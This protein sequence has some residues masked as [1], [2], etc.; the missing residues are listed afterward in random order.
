MAGRERRGG[1]STSII[2]YPFC[3]GGRVPSGLEDGMYVGSPYGNTRRGRRDGR[4]APGTH[5]NA[6]SL[7]RDLWRSCIIRMTG[8]LETSCS[9]EG[10]SRG[11]LS[12]ARRTYL[13][14]AMRCFFSSVSIADSIDVGDCSRWI[15]YRKKSISFFR[16][17]FP[18]RLQ[19][20]WLYLGGDEIYWAFLI[21]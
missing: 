9:S 16:S 19:H 20:M 14:Y 6:S 17:F 7:R 8:Q 3:V 2:T 11:Y 10:Q 21:L 15:L 18:S 13:P 5:T 4:I 12:T 1:G